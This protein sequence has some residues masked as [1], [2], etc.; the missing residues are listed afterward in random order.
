MSRMK[1]TSLKIMCALG[2]VFG[3]AGCGHLSSDVVWE[4]DG[5]P[6]HVPH[7]DQA[8]WRY[9]FVYHP[10][11]QVYFNPFTNAYYWYSGNEWVESQQLPE[12]IILDKN[13]A[14]V[15]RVNTK[16]PH[17][18]HR[19]ITTAV[20]GPSYGVFPSSANEMGGQFAVTIAERANED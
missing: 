5:T 4:A 13:L 18:Q 9:Q 3:L 19:T 16:P 20:A 12:H 14:R 17:V 10:E 2:V 8:W 7:N 1:R 6:R 11:A 15:V